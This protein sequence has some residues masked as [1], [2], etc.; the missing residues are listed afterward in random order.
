MEN[1]LLK[2][3]DLYSNLL[4]IDSNYLRGYVQHLYDVYANQIPPH[5]PYNLYITTFYLMESIVGDENRKLTTKNI[6]LVVFFNHIIRKSSTTLDEL[7]AYAIIHKRCI[8]DT[9][10]LIEYKDTFSCSE[11]WSTVISTDFYDIIPILA[12]D[13]FSKVGWDCDSNLVISGDY[14]NSDITRKNSDKP[15]Y[16]RKVSVLNHCNFLLYDRDLDK[17]ILIEPHGFTDKK[18]IAMINDMCKRTATKILLPFEYNTLPG[19]QMVLPGGHPTF[20]RAC[21][22]YG[23]ML[24][25]EYIKTDMDTRKYVSTIFEWLIN[26]DVVYAKLLSYLSLM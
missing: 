4:R 22:L 25:E 3:R 13:I 19:P 1:I 8:F 23:L 24:I 20:S 11:D 21:T 7:Y 12:T 5:I 2:G 17:W 16:I 18:R 6:A 9:R 26:P 10:L 14:S 15:F